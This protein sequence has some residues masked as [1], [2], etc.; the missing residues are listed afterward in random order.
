[1]LHLH[2]TA[3][4]TV[5]PLE[6]RTE[7]EVSMYV[8][9]PTVYDL[10]HIGHGRAN[11]TFDILR[12]YLSFTGLRVRHVANV[13]DVDDNIIKRA[14]DLGRTE[15]D[16]A[17]EFEARW[18]ESMDALGDLRPQDI[19]HA[20]G[21]IER[22]VAL[23][24]D[25]VAG[26]TAYE[27]PDGVYLEVS[28][29]DGYGLLAQQSL[30]SLQAGARVEANED[31]RSPLDFA[32][33]KK[34]KEGEPSWD[35]PWGQGR[36]GW[37]TECVVMSL[38]LLGEGFDLH[39]GGQDLMFPHHENERAQAV[40][41]GKVFAR[42]WMHHGW[43]EV[44]GTKMSKSLGNFATLPD[45]LARSDARAYRV[46]VLRAHYRSPIEVTP[47]T[48]ADAEKALTRLDGLARRFAR[49]D[50]ADLLGQ[51][52]EGFVIEG[53]PPAT[54][55][56]DAAVTAFRTH[57]DDD[58]DTPGALAT[59][60]ELVTAA[61]S[62]ADSGDEAEGGR[63][64]HSAAVLAAALGLTLRPADTEVDEES[65]RLVVERDE[66]RQARDFARADALRDE[67]VARGWTVEDTPAGTA[68]R[69]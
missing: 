38:D 53:I 24:G 42:H 9:G 55:V 28:K 31:K 5:R 63:L 27:T 23:V 14:A 4:G 34:A 49:F 1:M 56:D 6:M 46:L 60:F 57:M 48:L 40:A 11:L 65:A 37:H 52:D 30:E 13:T 26:G 51:T 64:A 32:L 61:H 2:D 66:A 62:A 68:I 59:I 36:P 47:D 15:A 20:T 54:G 67:L 29:V 18:W 12:R 19:P 69:R 44:D 10:P 8:C 25:L 21:Y 35:S 50:V 58:L 17:A 3:T 22:M 16:V 7:G 41:D 39:G 33:W 43:V 45:L